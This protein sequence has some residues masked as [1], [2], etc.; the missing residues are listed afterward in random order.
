MR[1]TVDSFFTVLIIIVFQIYRRSFGNETLFEYNAERLVVSAS[2]GN[3]R[4]SIMYNEKNFPTQ[5]QYS[6]GYTLYYGYNRRG[7]RSFLADNRGYNISYFY[8][9]QFRLFE[10]RQSSN[11]SLIC[12]FD[13]INGIVARKT[14][15]NGAYSLFT[16]SNGQLIQLEN[17]LPNQTLSS[18]NRYEYDHRGR[19]TKMTDSSG[20]TWSY[21][22]D[23]SGQLTGWT[24]SSGESIRYTYDNRGNR[25]V[26]ERG[27]STGRYSVNEMN[28][29]T[30]YNGTEQFSYDLNG[31]LA[32]KIT[33]TGAESYRYD[34]EGRLILTETLN[35]EY[36]LYY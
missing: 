21:R 29:Y 15:G 32:S 18:S 22:Y 9:S 17:Y 10:V 30:S 28:Q 33:L 31:N 7:Q 24:S 34:A 27:G 14:L 6:S 19:V 25:L 20:Q 23:V 2:N 4:V 13:Y 36:V 8:D 35:D 3:S 5:V 11:N 16:Y 1:S 12:L 26:M